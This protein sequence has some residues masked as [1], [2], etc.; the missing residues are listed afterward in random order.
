[1]MYQ[2]INALGESVIRLIE[3]SGVE[4]FI[5]ED[6]GNRHYQEYLGWI[7]EGNEPEVVEL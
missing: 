4:R 3:D 5:P 1:M 7:A 6:F 2:K